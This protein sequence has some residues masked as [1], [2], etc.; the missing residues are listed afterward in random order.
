MIKNMTSG[1]NYIGFNLSAKGNKTFSTFNPK[2]NE[3]N[4]QL[5]YEASTE[6]INQACNLAND[7]FKAFR[8]VTGKQR[9]SF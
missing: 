7:A 6:E 4:S 2:T 3:S 1:K 5:I 8:N 9:A